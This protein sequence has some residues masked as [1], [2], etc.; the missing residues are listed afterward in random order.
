M[1]PFLPLRA[2]TTNVEH[3]VGEVANDESCLCDTGGLD[4]GAEDILV[5]GQI[6]GRGNTFDRVKVATNRGKTA[7]SITNG[8]QTYYSAESFN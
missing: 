6:I 3:T 1:D 8:M 7:N 4:T 2:L 5:T